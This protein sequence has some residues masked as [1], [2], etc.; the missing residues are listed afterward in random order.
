MLT[1]H[2]GIRTPMTPEEKLFS[3]LWWMHYFTSATSN[4]PQCFYSMNQQYILPHPH[5]CSPRHGHWVDSLYRT[6]LDHMPTVTTRAATISTRLYGISHILT[7]KKLTSTV[8]NILLNEQTALC[9]AIYSALNVFPI[10]S[11][12][13]EIITYLRQT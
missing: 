2:P 1:T 12:G 5:Q 8:P 7:I 13:L 9:R 3:T 10:R 11:S 4:L 6:P